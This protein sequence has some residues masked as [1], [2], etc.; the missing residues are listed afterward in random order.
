MVSNLFNHADNVTTADLANDT[1][2]PACDNLAADELAYG[3]AR[4]LLGKMTANELLPDGLNGALR[5][6]GFSSPL[7]FF[8][9]NRV[10]AGRKL[11][12]HLACPRPGFGE[13]KGGVGA[14]DNSDRLRVTVTAAH[15][16]ERGVAGVSHANTERGQGNIPNYNPLASRRGLQRTYR[17]VGKELLQGYGFSSEKVVRGNVGATDS[18]R[19]RMLAHVPQRCLA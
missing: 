8:F 16:E 7:S 15:N 11:G 14:Q 5:L 9:A 19:Q 1:L 10:N 2:S 6:M 12:E 18:R 3:H 4:P 13:S 17:S